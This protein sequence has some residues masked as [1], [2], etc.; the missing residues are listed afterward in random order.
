MTFSHAPTAPEAIPSHDATATNSRTS[1]ITNRDIEKDPI[2]I[3]LSAP[4]YS[5]SEQA[6]PETPEKPTDYG[7][8]EVAIPVP[9][10]PA[11]P[12]DPSAF[13]EGG[14]KAWTVVAGAVCCLFV[15]FGWINCIGVFQTYYETHQLQNYSSQEVAWIPSTES[16]M[17]FFG[18]VWIGRL[19]DNYGPRYLIMAGMFFHVF[20]LMM[21]SISTKYYQFFLAQ[22]VCSALGCSLFF[23]PAMSAVTTWFFKK[24]AL[25]LG[26]TASGSSLGGVVFPIMVERLIPQVGFGWTMRICAFLIL[27]LGTIACL[28]VVSR[29]PP[30]PKPVKAMDF[31]RPFTEPTFAIL[32]FGTFLTWLGLFVPFTFIILASRA[33]H[34]PNSLATYLVAIMNAASTFGR[35]IPPFLADRVGRFNV[36]LSMSLLSSVIT[37]ALWVPSS[38]TAATVVYACIF[39][40]SSGAVASILPAVIA[41]ISNIHEIGVRTGALFSVAAVAT[42]IGSPIAG[43][44]IANDGY[45][46][47]QGF[48]GAILA[49]GTVVYVVLWVRLGGYKGKKV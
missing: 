44:I 16:F 3:G 41:Q 26:I 5:T 30:R 13:P 22:G 27:G 33:H 21:A 34:V 10:Q 15:S 28:T 17:M 24:R 4:E 46:S 8:N 7:D 45:R 42:L 2:D 1:S 37:L 12:L 25:A 14:L 18:G 38:G 36:F 39:G 20:G 32:A 47:M 9:S 48:G 49:G 35:T 31:F 43:Q 23:Y 19:Y 6:A 40:F 11:N 29:I